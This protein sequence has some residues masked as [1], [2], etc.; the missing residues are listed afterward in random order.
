MPKQKKR[1]LVIG[2]GIS[3][4]TA[5]YRLQQWA[6]ETVEWRLIERDTRL[7]GKIRTAREDG[8]VIE[9]GPDSFHGQKPAAIELCQELGLAD[10]LIGPKTTSG[11]T[12][13]W[14]GGRLRA[15]PEAMSLVPSRLT[16][17]LR[18]SLISWPGKL[19]MGMEAIIPPR[20]N[21][22]ADESIAAFVRRRLGH[23]AVEKIAAP[24]MAGIHA[25]DVE[26]LSLHST[27]PRFH[28]IEREHGGLVRAMW[29]RR[30]QRTAT[31]P[32]PPYFSL[33]GGLQ[34]LVDALAG[35]LDPARID[36]G[37]HILGIWRIN[38]AY[39]VFVDG[40]ET[41]SADSVV[42]A[43][44]AAATANILED[45]APRLAE[46]LRGLRSVSTAT[47]SLGFRQSDI[48][49]MP[50]GSGYVVAD[51]QRGGVLGCTWSSNKFHERAPH[52]HVL[53]RVFVGG[54]GAEGCAEQGDARLIAR[55]RGEV[56]RSLGVAAE[57]ILTK[58]YRWPKSHP[59][60]EIGHQERIADIEHLVSEY[61]GIYLAGASYRG[62]GIP[63][64]IQSGNR[65]AGQIARAAGSHGSPKEM[66]REFVP[67]TV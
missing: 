65:V 66:E 41:I 29:A 23:E 60:Y 15:M 58:V 28:Q 7:G 18:S 47:V 4:L 31:K 24:L 57:P 39:R 38:G 11:S 55:A 20:M 30:R 12:L 16:P 19:R 27:F 52:D 9:A 51:E 43:T 25:G 40:A 48:A 2:G 59:Q 54:A 45:I 35:T 53:V 6:G 8:F 3:G 50:D 17:F 32:S 33:K 21:G 61:P 34:Q 22:F 56:R 63:D 46:K 62:I 42:F 36:L 5:A 10:D 37:R 64:C 44:P 67:H 26:R 49:R 13:I 14:S 1:V